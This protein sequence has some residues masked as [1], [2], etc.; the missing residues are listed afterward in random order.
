MNALACSV[1]WNQLIS[2]EA[3]Q[4][5]CVRE[6]GTDVPHF[7][8]S[9]L[10]TGSW[11]GAEGYMRWRVTRTMGE[12]DDG[13]WFS[14]PR[15]TS[16]PIYISFLGRVGPSW[17][18]SHYPAGRFK[19]V[20]FQNSAGTNPR[21]TIFSMPIYSERGSIGSYAY[22]TLG[23]DL[24]A[25]G[26]GCDEFDNCEYNQSYAYPNHRYKEDRIGH[27][28]W[29]FIVM[30]LE[31]NRTKTYVWSQDGELSGLYA[32]SRVAPPD[33][34]NSWNAN[35][36][37]AVRLLAYIEATTAGDQ[38]AYMDIGHI[39]VT[40]TLPSPPEGF[41]SGDVRPRAP[42]NVVVE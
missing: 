35:T 18:S 17:W 16:R 40:Q 14:F 39:R 37:A 36:W 30:S 1:S 5:A 12:D 4:N 8:R 28:Q 29:Y 9:W 21:P 42:G 23:P 11:N 7:T 10:T 32:Q 25:G 13:Y 2:T 15:T 41:V 24:E 31:D 33:T 3:E 20:I 22:R 26:Q 27:D 6:Y 38:N 34:L 19:M